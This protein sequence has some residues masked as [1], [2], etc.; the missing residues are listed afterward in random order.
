MATW[1]ESL[2][3]KALVESEHITC[4]SDCRAKAAIE[5]VIREAIEKCA[6]F[7]E[8]RA[9]FYPPDIFLPPPPGQHAK[10]VDGCSAAALRALAPIWADGLRKLLTAEEPQT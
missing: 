3:R 7:V 5:A 6:E 8:S 1:V 2:E 4:C 9:A 10:S